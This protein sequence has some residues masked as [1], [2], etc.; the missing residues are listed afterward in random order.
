MNQSRPTLFSSFSLKSR[1][2]FP[3]IIF[4]SFQCQ[5]Y[6]KNLHKEL[7]IN[8]L[9][10]FSAQMLLKEN[11]IFSAL[12]KFILGALFVDGLLE[13]NCLVLD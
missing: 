5:K 7:L 12:L 4:H 2:T 9:S 8:I 10:K 13:Q 3:R 11:D 1:P 6:F